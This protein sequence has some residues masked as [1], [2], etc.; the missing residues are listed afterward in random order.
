LKQTDFDGKS[1]TF[2]PVAVV[3]SSEKSKEITINPNP[4]KSELIIKYSNLDNGNA[5]IKVFDIMGNNV[6]YRN[7]EIPE[8]N[9]T[10]NL[11]LQSLPI[12]VYFVEYSSGDFIYHQKVLKE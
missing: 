5:I 6:F 11:D 7:I 12:G 3:C 10:F 4:F 2:S 8:S 1:E 9:G